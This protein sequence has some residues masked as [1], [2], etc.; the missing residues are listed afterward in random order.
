MKRNL[1]NTTVREAEGMDNRNVCQ[2]NVWGCI[3][4]V[5]V[6]SITV[7]RA[8]CKMLVLQEGFRMFSFFHGFGHGE[9]WSVSRTWMDFSDFRWIWIWLVFVS[10]WIFR[11]FVGFGFFG[12]F[13]IWI[14]TVFFWIW[15]CLVFR[16]TWFS[17]FSR[18][19]ISNGI[20]K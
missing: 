8:S 11:I 17:V 7:H 12:F 20:F 13:W 5:C 4:G 14:W 10:D 9:T 18:D 6:F 16:R 2:G 1:G 3:P 19:W 15:I